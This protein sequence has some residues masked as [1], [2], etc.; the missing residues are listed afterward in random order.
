MET[1]TI[2]FFTLSFTFLFQWVIATPHLSWTFFKTTVKYFFTYTYFGNN[3]CMMCL[4]NSYFYLVQ[5]RLQDM[6]GTPQLVTSSIF[7]IVFW[8]DINHLKRIHYIIHWCH[9][10]STVLSSW[11]ERWNFMVPT[12]L[13]CP[14][15][16]LFFFFFPQKAMNLHSLPVDLPLETVIVG[17]LVW[18]S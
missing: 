1:F 2:A 8:K 9:Y 7:F 14:S 3:I 11:W 5:H 12:H 13:L 6:V 16:R 10:I 18:V 4:R 15:V 17:Q